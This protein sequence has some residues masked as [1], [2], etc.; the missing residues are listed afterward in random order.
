MRHKF[1]ERH[2]SSTGSSLAPSGVALRAACGRLSRS[3]DCVFR[4]VNY[5]A[6]QTAA[7]RYARSRPYFH[8][9]VIDRIRAFLKLEGRVPMSLDV[10]CGTGLSAVAATEIADSVIATDISGSMLG[11]AP[12]HERI[13]YIEAPAEQLP[14]ESGSADLMTVSLAFHWFDRARFLAEAHRVLR[15]TGTLVIYSNGFFGRMKENPEFTD[16]NRGSY[17]TRYPIPP[18]NDQAFT[19]DDAKNNG[20]EFV[21]RER[22][23]NEITFSPEELANYLMTQSNVIAAVEQGSESLQDVHAWLLE[24]ADSLF[25]SPTG[26]FIFGGEIW[27][28]RP[29]APPTLT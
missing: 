6:Y 24:S 19:D 29:L 27:F 25:V 26:S 23:T 15:E 11:Q 21:G 20:F 1:F 9:L 14:V 28:L 8:P 17:L 2:H 3:A 18:R 22:Y 10:G 4:I 12:K 16:W 7:E 5:F 13:R